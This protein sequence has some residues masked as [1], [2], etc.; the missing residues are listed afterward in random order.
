MAALESQLKTKESSLR[1]RMRMKLPK[2]N[3]SIHLT[4]GMS[5]ATPTPG[6]SGPA[7]PTFSTQANAPHEDQV[8][9][10]EH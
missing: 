2:L 3:P 10:P 5:L 6:K 8:K 1:N 4:A 7:I 9:Q